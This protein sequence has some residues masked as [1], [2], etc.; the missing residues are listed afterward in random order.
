MIED[1]HYFSGGSA[2]V[3]RESMSQS[4]SDSA[5]DTLGKVKT[6]HIQSVYSVTLVHVCCCNPY[7]AGGL[8]VRV[9]R[10]GL[11]CCARV[12]TRM[13]QVDC[14]SFVMPPV[15]GGIG[16]NPYGAVGRIIPQVLPFVQYW[17]LSADYRKK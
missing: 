4:E 7:G 1:S 2:S 16:C 17:L 3:N 15:T 12:A 10:V 5:S 8:R 11:T 9:L 14:E 6:I 13:E